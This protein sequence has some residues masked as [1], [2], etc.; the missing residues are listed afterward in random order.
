[1]VSTAHV[2]LPTE[3]RLEVAQEARMV[4]EA[5]G[6]VKASEAMASAVQTATRVA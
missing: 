4:L 6:V 3:V 1:M 2:R 5:T